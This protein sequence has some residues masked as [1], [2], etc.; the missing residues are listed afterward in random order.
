MTLASLLLHD[1]RWFSLDFLIHSAAAAAA[2][3]F[4][5]H[6]CFAKFE[7]Q[8]RDRKSLCLLNSVIGY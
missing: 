1:A 4:E 8:E 7:F 2:A 5:L 3:L 6:F